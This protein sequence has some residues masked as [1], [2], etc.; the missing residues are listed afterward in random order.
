MNNLVFGKYIPIDSLMHRLDP[1]AKLIGLFLMIAA[2][3]IPKSWWVF[4]VIA[5][6]LALALLLAKIGI[7]MIV[8]SFKPMIMMMIFLLV[9]NSLTIKT[10]DV[11]FTIGTFAVYKDAIFNTLFVITRLLLMISITTLLTATTNPLDLTL[12]IEW[13][14]KPLE[15]IHFPAHEV[16]MMVSIALRFIPTIIE[17]TMRIM[18]AQ[19]SRGV[20][21]ENGRLAEKISAI[22][23]LI[24]PLFSVAFERAYELADAME[25]RGY[26]PGEKRT[27]YHVLHFRFMDYLFI[28][29]CMAILAFSILSRIYL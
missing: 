19:K 20:D 6:L 29:I 25:A 22:L 1:R 11:M 7:K 12:G 17:E 15:V 23:S 16:A 4:L 10:G 8:Q 5:L 18:N 28:F 9:I 24:V 21:F 14:L 2:V 26:V 3:F 27:R 13:L